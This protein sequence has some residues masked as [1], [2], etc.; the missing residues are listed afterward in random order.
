MKATIDIKEFKRV[1]VALKPFTSTSIYND[2]MQYIKA[3]V[4]KDN[5]EIRFEAL[6]G[7]RLA[8]EYLKCSADSSF[9]VYIKPFNILKSQD[10]EIELEIIDNK[11]H[12]STNEWSFKFIQPEGMWFDTS[13]VANRDNQDKA[14]RI[15]VNAKLLREAL[16]NINMKH[17]KELVEIEIGSNPIEPIIIRSAKDRR[18]FRLVLPVRLSD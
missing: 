9:T 1:M 3:D 6:D 16:G 2:K 14:V 5:Q 4:D 18:N 8:V 17:D 10:S 15:G 7:H 13:K 11:L 12:I